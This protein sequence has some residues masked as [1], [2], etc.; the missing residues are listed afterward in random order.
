MAFEGCTLFGCYLLHFQLKLLLASLISPRLEFLSLLTSSL[1]NQGWFLTC[2]DM[3]AASA[4]VTGSDFG[5]ELMGDL[6][7]DFLSAHLSLVSL[8]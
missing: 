5:K 8:K 7:F 6:L 1:T 3:T 2:C 4:F